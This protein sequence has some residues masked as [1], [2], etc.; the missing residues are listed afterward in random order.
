MRGNFTLLSIIVSWMVHAISYA[1]P[2]QGHVMDVGANQPMQGVSI[3][4]IH[5]SERLET[6]NEGAFSVKVDEGQLIE[7]R[8]EGYKVLRVRIPQGK[9][10]SYFRVMMQKA[11]T[12]VVDYVHERGAAPDYKTDSLRYYALYKET[13]EVPKLT[14]IDVIQH[15]FSAMSK[16]NRQIWA[17]QEEFRQFQEQKYIDYTFNPKLVSNITGLQGDSLQTYMELYRPS[18][19]HLRSMSEYTYYNYIKRTAEIYRRR[20]VKPRINHGRSPQ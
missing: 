15:P 3:F 6:D 1:Q 14:G 16:K 9:R 11:G 7:F 8:K 13:L 5:T 19:P 4:N 10:P 12:D 2:M 18:Y 17:F 20:A